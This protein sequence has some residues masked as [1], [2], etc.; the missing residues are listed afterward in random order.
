MKLEFMQKALELAKTV[1]DDIPIAAII[2]K[3]DKI[4]SSAVNE[5]ELAQNS[6]N[7]AEMI[8]IQRANKILNNWRLNDCEMYVTLEPCSMCASAIVQAR[9]KSVFFGAYDILNGAM[10]SKIDIRNIINSNISV[11]GGIL[12]E[13][14][15][16]VLKNYFK[17]IRNYLDS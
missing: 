15:T 13:E 1:R 3:N 6:V 5:R 16:K 12:E 17:N 8:A 7:H 4:I 9:I 14:C 11:T 10:G 2:I